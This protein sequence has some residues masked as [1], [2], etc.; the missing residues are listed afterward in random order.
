M[1]QPRQIVTL[2]THADLGSNFGQISGRGVHIWFEWD[3][4]RYDTVD[5]EQNGKRERRLKVFRQPIGD[6][7]TC[8][9]SYITEARAAELY[10]AEFEYF[11]KHGDMPT[12]GTPISELPGISMSQIQI[13]QLSGLRSI[14][15]ILSV[16]D[17]VINRIG[18]EGRYVRSVASEWSARAKAGAEMISVAEAKTSLGA[19]L[20]SE[21]E[22]ADRA[23]AQ[24]MQLQARLDLLEKMFQ[25]G[26][27][28]LA[29]IMP[30]FDTMQN[31]NDGPGVD[32]TPNPLADGSG[33]MED[34]DP[35]QD[36]VA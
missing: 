4:V 27:S 20:A 11:T 2:Q 33:E 36:Q 1:Q 17:E 3:Q 22:R 15:D 21:K 25:Q 18:H 31:R 29:P 19:A 24:N 8:A 32:Q 30:T 16:P 34:F 13:M 9:T 14:E 7:N 35:M 28:G 12:I 6:P 5:A 26:G 10:P 23:Q